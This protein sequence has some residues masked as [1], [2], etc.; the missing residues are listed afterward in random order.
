MKNACRNCKK[1]KLI[2]FVTMNAGKLWNY[3]D[4]SWWQIY[5]KEICDIFSV[6][7][8]CV[9]CWIF[10]FCYVIKMQ[11]DI[12]KC[13]KCSYCERTRT[14]TCIA[15]FFFCAIQLKW[16]KN[17]NNKETSWHIFLPITPIKAKPS[18]YPHL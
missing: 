11:F 1:K 17:I 15:I 3:N 8:F 16:I 13:Y 7:L 10:V 4:H 6:N 2:I 5:Q 18:V 9:L 12:A 14:R